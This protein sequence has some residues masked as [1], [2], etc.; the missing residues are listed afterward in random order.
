MRLSWVLEF[1]GCWLHCLWHT[2]VRCTCGR[3]VTVLTLNLVSTL[4]SAPMT[5]AIRKA[6]W[7]VRRLTVVLQIWIWTMPSYSC[8]ATTG[9]IILVCAIEEVMPCRVSSTTWTVRS[10]LSSRRLLAIVKSARG[11]HSLITNALTLL[12]QL[13]NPTVAI[14]WKFS[15]FHWLG[16]A[17]W[18]IEVWGRLYASVFV[19][20]KI[21]FIL[22]EVVARPAGHVNA[23]I[24]LQNWS[25]VTFASSWPLGLT[26]ISTITEGRCTSLVRSRGHVL[27]FGCCRLANWIISGT[28]LTCWIRRYKF[29]SISAHNWRLR[30]LAFHFRKCCKRGL[31]AQSKLGHIYLSITIHVKSTQDCNKFLFCR[32]MPH[33]AQVTL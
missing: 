26:H 5:V 29:R 9:H 31:H 32:Q 10:V 27:A 12:F 25:S 3:G 22:A 15:Y 2:T 11:H 19:V 23:W 28:H 4:W 30:P 6:E 33:G 14:R 8:R 7:R 17:D 21:L 20:M 13:F 24:A 18:F 16:K 1:L